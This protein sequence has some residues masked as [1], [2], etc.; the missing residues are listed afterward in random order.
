MKGSAEMKNKYKVNG[1]ATII[2]ISYKNEII[3]T[4]IDTEDLEKIKAFPNTWHAHYDNNVKNYYISGAYICDGRIVNV[5]LH[6]LVMNTP[7][8]LMVDHKNHNT[9]DNRKYNLRNVTNYENSQNMIK[10]NIYKNGKT[11]EHIEM[12]KKRQQLKKAI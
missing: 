4:I 7:K 10:D 6:R 1:D 2:Y 5:Q 3:E 8:T 12:K 9:V 11:A